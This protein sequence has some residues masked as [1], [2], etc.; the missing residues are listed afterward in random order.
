MEVVVAAVGRAGTGLLAAALEEYR[1]RAARYWPLDVREVKPEPGRS[2]A[3]GVVTAREWERL[4]RVVAGEVVGCDEG[5]ER[6]SSAAF[7]AWLQDRREAGTTVTFLLGGANGLD[8]AALVACRRRLSLAPWTLPH[9]LAR[10]VL[11]EQLYRAGTIV[12]GEPY[13]K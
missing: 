5:G 2:I 11:L 8:A 1:A 3:A 13:H 12:A 4:R 10:L 9:E 7:A 6:L